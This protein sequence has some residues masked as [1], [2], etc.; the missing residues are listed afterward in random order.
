MSKQASEPAISIL[1]GQKVLA[2]ISDRGDVEIV[3]PV[4]L[5]PRVQEA[6]QRVLAARAAVHL[7]EP[8]DY[9]TFL[10]LMDRAYLIVTDSGGIQEEAPALGTPVLVT[11]D[12]TE[13]PEAIAA[14]TARLL[15]TSAEALRAALVELLDNPLSYNTMAQA[16]NPFGDGRA[17]KRIIDRILQEH[18]T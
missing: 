14:G 9:Q 2:D 4:H 11:R 15:G 18:R 16:S 8:Q 12:T 13:R 3:Y 1:P 6:A 5:N 10:Y 7:I 17:S